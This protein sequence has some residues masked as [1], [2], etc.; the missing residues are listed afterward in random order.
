[1]PGDMTRESRELTG[2][3]VF[4]L[5]HFSSYRNFRGISLNTVN[6]QEC[7]ANFIF[8]IH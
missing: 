2:F 4:L 6:A 5:L 3:I 8:D 7:L 1:M